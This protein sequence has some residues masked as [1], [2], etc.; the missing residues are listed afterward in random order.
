M[1]DEETE[2]VAPKSG[3]S[4]VPLLLGV[5]SVALIAVLAVVLLR[6]S[7]GNAAKATEEHPAPSSESAAGPGGAPGPTVKL[8][9]FTARLHAGE[10]DHYARL[11]IELEVATEKDKE[12]VTAAVPR[13]RDNFIVFFSDTNMEDLTGSLALS[14]TKEKLSSRLHE[15]VPGQKIRGVYFTDLVIQ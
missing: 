3:G 1:S 12:E 2:I 13:I 15:L 5:N 14:R 6:P 8:A 11:S 9:D 10:A 4:L 7:G